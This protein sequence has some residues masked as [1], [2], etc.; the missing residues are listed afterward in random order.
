MSGDVNPAHV[1][2]AFARSDMFRK[3]IAPDIWG[4]AL[5]PAVLGPGL[6][7]PATIHLNQSLSFRRPVGL[8]DTVTVR[9]TVHEKRAEASACSSIANA[10][11]R[12]AKR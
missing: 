10:L 9:V 4:G 1:D 8:G 5:I 12:M 2:E 3:V 11:I 6:S 7:G